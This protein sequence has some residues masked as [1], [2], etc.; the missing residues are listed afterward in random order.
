MY[1]FDFN[2]KEYGAATAHLSWDEDAAYQRLLRAYYLRESPLPA[3]FDAVCRLTRAQT[4]RQKDAVKSA[5]EEFFYM[6][7]DG[8]HQYRCD[9]ELERFHERTRD[10]RAK[11]QAAR[12]R[13]QRHREHRSLLFKALREYGVTA[14]WDTTNVV[15]T[16]MLAEVRRSREEQPA[17]KVAQTA[18]S[19][20]QSS[21]ELEPLLAGD[22]PV[23]DLS[24][25]CHAP[26]TRTKTAISVSVP[27]SVSVPDLCK[28]NLDQELFTHTNAQARANTQ[29]ST[30]ETDADAAASAVVCERP[31]VEISSKN[32]GAT[33]FVQTRLAEPMPIVDFFTKASDD[34]PPDDLS[35][36]S[37]E[38]DWWMSGGEAPPPLGDDGGTPIAGEQHP[39]AGSEPQDVA[40]GASKQHCRFEE[41]WAI[42]PTKSGKKVCLAAWKKRKLDRI[43]EKII[44]DVAERTLRDRRWLRGIIPNPSTYLNQ[45]RWQDEWESSSYMQQA[46]DTANAMK[47]SCD[48]ENESPYVVAGVDYSGYSAV[49]RANAL[50]AKEFLAELK[51]MREKEQQNCQLPPA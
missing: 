8:W 36:L 34:L 29:D 10:A 46:G 17:R 2:I 25:T 3:S 51:S 42:Y 31:P 28:Q 9:E 18:N 1:N 5:L 45:D 41:F 23:T 7:D 20:A 47:P 22:A 44:A 14:P 11:Q 4:K 26:V 19:L 40:G 27:V 30:L 33:S 48:T 39:I 50:E 38:A 16:E 15:L 21:A 35:L 12:E 49:G 37:T 6:E 32:D 24:Q 43:A 13:Q